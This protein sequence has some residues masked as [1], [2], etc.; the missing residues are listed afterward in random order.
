MANDRPVVKVHVHGCGMITIWVVAVFVL[1]LG[2]DSQG[3]CCTLSRFSQPSLSC[4]T[5]LDRVAQL[6]ERK[7][8][9]IEVVF[10]LQ[11]QF[12][13]LLTA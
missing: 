5:P 11:S 4:L 6:L 9:M 1:W 8:S 10:P 12:S 13:Y 3:M 2:A 7:L